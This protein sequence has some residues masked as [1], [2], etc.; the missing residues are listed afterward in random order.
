M[1]IILFDK[2]SQLLSSA[3][4][5]FSG[6]SNDVFNS[7]KED[8]ISVTNLRND[9]E[10]FSYYL[11][12]LEKAISDGDRKSTVEAILLARVAICNAENAYSNL[13][14]SIEALAV[15]LRDYKK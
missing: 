4:G 11:S 12:V 10:N 5:Q 2:Y 15:E 3:A 6:V 9:I 8:V 14:E 13:A 1:D 7:I